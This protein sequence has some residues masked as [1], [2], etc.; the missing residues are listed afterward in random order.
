[1]Q[2][3]KNVTIFFKVINQLKSLK[4]R[5]KESAPCGFFREAAFQ[6]V[7]LFVI[8]PADNSKIKRKASC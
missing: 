6:T 7:N 1:M 3:V 8:D 5:L 4:P 2:G